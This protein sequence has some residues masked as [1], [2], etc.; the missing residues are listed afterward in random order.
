MT[1]AAPAPPVGKPLASTGVFLGTFAAILGLI[2]GLLVLDLALARI[3]REER[4]RQAANA[5][6]EGRALLAAGRP[7]DAADRLATATTLERDNVGYGLALAQAL[8]AHGKA[9]DAEE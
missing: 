6:A 1:D 9:T 7:G 3:D 5:F 2:V 4:R 8:L